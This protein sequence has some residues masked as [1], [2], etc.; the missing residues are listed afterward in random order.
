MG[1]IL[2]HFREFFSTAAGT[3]AGHRSV[4]ASITFASAVTKINKRLPHL[5]DIYP[6]VIRMQING[7]SYHV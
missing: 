4:R 5:T 6:R 1:P 2:K 3:E 7:G